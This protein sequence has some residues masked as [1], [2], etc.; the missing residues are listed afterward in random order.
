MDKQK[1]DGSAHVVIIVVLVI[2]LVGMLGF[3]FWQN[4]VNKKDSID[5]AT[6]T[7]NSS[8]KSTPE[9]TTR[10]F[11]IDPITFD[12]PKSWSEEGEISVPSNDLIGSIKLLPGEKLRTVY[13][14]GTEYFYVTVATY[15][16]SKNLTPQEWLTNDAGNPH[17]G[18]GIAVNDDTESNSEINGYDAYFRNSI[19]PEY[20]DIN[21]VLSSDGTIVYIQARTY[22]PSSKLSGVGDF[23]KFEPAIKSLVESVRIR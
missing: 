11:T 10:T 4:I 3:V 18:L 23:R 19:N 16:N 5:N 2:A 7:E 17:G 8:K 12:T 22:E 6:Q 13:G 9:V 14:D 1:R 21:Y 20:Q 15:R